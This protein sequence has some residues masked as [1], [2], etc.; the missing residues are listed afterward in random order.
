M[1]EF[2]DGVL[3]VVA[4]GKTPFDLA[5]KTREHLKKF[6]TLGVVLNRVDPQHTG[7]HYYYG[8]YQGLGAK[9]KS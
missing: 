6:R 1:A 8:Y 3:V 9:E 7:G 5:Q 2:C 4:A